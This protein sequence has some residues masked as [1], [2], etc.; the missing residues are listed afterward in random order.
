[1]KVFNPSGW[2]VEAKAAG[3][4]YDLPAFAEV[5]IYDIYHVNHICQSL[6]YRGIVS[7]EYGPKAREE[8]KTFEEYKKS[9]EIK[10]LKALLDFKERCLND[11]KQAQ[12]EAKAQ[13][14]TADVENIVV[15]KF[16]KEV[17]LV[18]TWL[19][20]AG[21]KAEEVKMEEVVEKRPSWDKGIADEPKSNAGKG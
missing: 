10:G 4:F 2:K 14:S 5:E 19:K 1:M 16:E 6:K 9:Q 15:D 20:E 13:G 3:E 18:K 7:L 17:K 21:Y 8:F 12:K 11:E